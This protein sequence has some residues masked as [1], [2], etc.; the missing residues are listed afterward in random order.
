MVFALPDG[1]EEVLERGEEVRPGLTAD[2]SHAESVAWTRRR[3]REVG[4]AHV[5]FEWNGRLR[6]GIG[7][8]DVGYVVPG[9]GV[10]NTR[11]RE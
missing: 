6:F 5:L 2:L 4:V 1:G 7:G 3:E 11:K 9:A 10:T 8:V